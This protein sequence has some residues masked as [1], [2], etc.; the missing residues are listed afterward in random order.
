[1]HLRPD[2]HAVLECQALVQ[3]GVVLD[4]AISA[5][6]H[7]L[8]DVH[9]RADD[10]PRADHRVLA[11]VDLAPDA[12][13]IANFRLRGNFSGWVNESGCHRREN[14]ILRPSEQVGTLKP[15]VWS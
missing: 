12:A 8:A 14:V 15:C 13:P 11:D 9:P 7:V 5:K 10:R 3:Q 4:L 1:A 2:E 6:T